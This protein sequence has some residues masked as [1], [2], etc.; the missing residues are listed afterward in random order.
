MTPSIQPSAY[1]P[2]LEHIILIGANDLSAFYIKFIRAYSPI[3]YRI[4]AVL[5]DEL[6]L[7]GRTLVGVP[8]VA[9]V[10]N[11][12]RTI[13]EFE[14]HGV[15]T[16]RIVVGGDEALLSKDALQKSAGSANSVKFLLLFVPELIGL[17]K[18]DPRQSNDVLDLSKYRK[19]IPALAGYHKTK[20][21]IDFFVSAA[22]ILILSP[23]FTLISLLILFD[24]GSP[25]IFWQQRIG[26]N[27]S[28][29][30]PL[31][32]SNFAG[33]LRLGRPA[34]FRSATLIVGWTIAAQNSARR[35]AA[36]IQRAGRRYVVD[37]TA[38]AFAV[39]S[40]GEQ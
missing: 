37:W 22:A 31:Q 24:V 34:G 25:V 36:I 19:Q 33:A 2:T 7:F 16:D 17:A 28:S 40:A 5:D 11:I 30:L 35:V 15:H 23:L 12:E 32:V 1:H 3:Y 29:F 4:V 38:T 10:Q 14:V 6:S 13:D 18:I 39:R 9:T 20:R 27:G 21:L 26:Q 8:V